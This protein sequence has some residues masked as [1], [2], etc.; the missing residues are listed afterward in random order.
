M[1]MHLCNIHIYI[2]YSVGVYT[3][4]LIQVHMCMHMC[5]YIYIYL[6]MSVYVCVY[7]CAYV[8]AI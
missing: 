2:I 3:Y 6:H 8:N 4:M 7:A 1:Y 5:V